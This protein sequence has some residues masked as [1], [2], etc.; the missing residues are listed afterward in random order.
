[1]LKPGPVKPQP[2]SPSKCSEKKGK[3]FTKA[4]EALAV[5]GDAEQHG[6]NF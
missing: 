3:A 1:M 5:T 6:A 4:P 2:N